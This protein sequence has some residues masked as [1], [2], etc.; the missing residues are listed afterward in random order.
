MTTKCP[1]FGHDVYY[2][3]RVAVGQK[4]LTCLASLGLADTTPLPQFSTGAHLAEDGRTVTGC[5]ASA[6]APLARSQQRFIGRLCPKVPIPALCLVLMSLFGGLDAG[7]QDHLTQQPPPFLSR[8]GMCLLLVL[9][10]GK[11]VLTSSVVAVCATRHSS[12]G[13]TT[14]VTGRWRPRTIGVQTTCHRRRRS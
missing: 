5:T 7:G 14:T 6:A 11:L 1:H 4:F 8:R 12:R 3:C 2:V 9:S 13:L 10:R